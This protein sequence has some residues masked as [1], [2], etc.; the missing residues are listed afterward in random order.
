[1][2]KLGV[3]D[4]GGGLRG[5]YAAGVL[6][7]CLEQ[8]I[9]FDCCIGVSAGSANLASYLAGQ[10]GRNYVFYLDYS[11]RK[12]YMSLKNFLRTGSYIDMDYI[13]GALSNAGGE[14]PLNY[15]ALQQNPAEFF[16]VATKAVSGQVKYFTKADLQQDDYRV[17]MASSSIP[18]VN[19]PYPFAGNL[20][21]DGALSDPV[22]IAKAFQ[23]GCDKV[24]LILT[25]PCDVSRA[26]GKDLPIARLIQHRYPIAADN[27]RQRAERYNQSVQLAKTYQAQGKVLIISPA[28]MN[29]VNTLTKNR[30]ALERFYHMGQKDA[31][32]IRQWLQPA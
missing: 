5:I 20:Y 18:G 30:S 14:N 4:V 22:P 32:R 31:K 2:M 8:K 19:R 6:D 23:Q 12:E 29:G 27:L 7:Y 13:Y 25:R 11:F 16:I 21:F 24:V 15:T 17:F 1:M 10:K 26:P 3:V 28:D 9:S